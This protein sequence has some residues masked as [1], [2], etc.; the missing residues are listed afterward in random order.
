VRSIFP[1]LVRVC[2]GVIPLIPLFRQVHEAGE[3]MKQYASESLDRYRKLVESGKGEA[4]ETLFSK[5][6]QTNGQGAMPYHEVRD[7][8]VNYIAAGSDTVSTTLSYLTWTLSKKLDVRDRLVEELEAL[9]RGFGAQE[10]RELPYLNGVI[11]E[12]LR[13]HTAAPAPFPRLVPAEGAD[14]AGYSLAGGVE[15]SA[16]AYSMHR[17]PAIFPDPDEFRPERWAAPTAAMKDAF[18]PFGRGVRGE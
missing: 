13:I 15:V 16:Q 18:I 5:V 17:D 1:L 11:N 12:T 4:P 2:G 6:Y 9:P 10:L 8:A 7:E 3:R 14:L